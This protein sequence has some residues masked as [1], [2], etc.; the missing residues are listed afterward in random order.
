MIRHALA[1]SEIAVAIVLLTGAGLLI[2]SFQHVLDV[3]PG[4]RHDHLLALE[5]DTAQPSPAQLSQLKNDERIA[6][7]RRQAMQ[8]DDMVQ[9]I[10]SLPGMEAAGGVSVLPLGTAMQSASRFLVEGQA[11]PADG[12]RPVA[13]TRNIS[14]GYF[15]AMGIPLRRS[16]LLDP[17]DYA[18][19]NVVINEELARRFWPAG[20]AIGKR[21]NLCTLAPQPCWTNGVGVV[22]MS[23]NMV[24]KRF[25][26][27]IFT[28]VRDGLHT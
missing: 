25:P 22:G 1:V 13:E 16:R 5:V 27:L 3:N 17:H 24:L 8:F 6:L 26:R 4:F 7:L 10:E 12:V 18:S 19:Q 2:R 21:I 9:Q 23:T 20:D 28:A 14:P 11:V 15:A